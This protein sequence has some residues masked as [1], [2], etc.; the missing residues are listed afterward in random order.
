MQ[1]ILQSWFIPEA[2][3]MSSG[4]WRFSVGGF[5]TSGAYGYAVGRSIAFA[6]V[7]PDCAEPGSELEIA[8]LG[9]RRSARV[10]AEPLYDA[11][12]RRLRA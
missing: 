9:D 3:R 7:E 11:Q 12:D 10:L 1:W 6:F 2:A 5:T 4:A 8:I